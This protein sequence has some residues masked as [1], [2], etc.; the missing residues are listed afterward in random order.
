M[1]GQST[2]RASVH[3]VHGRTRGQSRETEYAETEYARA[4]TLARA[5]GAQPGVDGL[6]RGTMQ[7]LDAVCSR[8]GNGWQHATVEGHDQ[9]AGLPMGGMGSGRRGILMQ[10]TGMV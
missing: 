5:T 3:A 1:L 6:S 9:E 10:W 4:Y 8:G 7:T 2:A